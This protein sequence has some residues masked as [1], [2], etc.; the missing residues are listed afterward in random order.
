MRILRTMRLSSD[1]GLSAA[2]QPFQTRSGQHKMVQPYCTNTNPYH[3]EL[4]TIW[5]HRRIQDFVRGGPRPSWPPGGGGPRPSWP[6]PHYLGEQYF[7]GRGGGP[8]PPWPPLDPRM[9]SKGYRS[10]Q[11]YN[12]NSLWGVGDSQGNTIPQGVHLYC[13]IPH[14]L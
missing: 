12:L 3:S 6:A 10:A 2:Y 13:T 11:H 14:V 9:G 4:T 7:V 5:F 8:R 1:N